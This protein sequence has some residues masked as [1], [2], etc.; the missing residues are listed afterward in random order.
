[1]ATG[2]GEQLL[3]MAQSRKSAPPAEQASLL[4][5]LDFSPQNK[6]LQQ[7]G[8]LLVT[9][10]GAVLVAVVAGVLPSGVSDAI[11]KGLR[12]LF[13]FVPSAEGGWICQPGAA[14]SLVSV[15]HKVGQQPAAPG[16]D[17]AA[18]T[19]MDPM[20]RDD[21]ELLAAVA[22]SVLPPRKPG[23]PRRFAQLAGPVRGAATPS[24]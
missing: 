2:R 9:L 8:A 24:R 5:S 17:L 14:S 19:W 18:S 16:L 7:V 12:Q 23:R 22:F 21:E 4:H 11:G 10:C 20:V 15:L 1:M 6:R 3:D 13:G